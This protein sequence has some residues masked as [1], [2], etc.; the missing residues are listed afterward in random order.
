MSYCKLK[1][2]FKF[3]AFVILSECFSCLY[4]QGSRSTV[5]V[6]L[7]KSTYWTNLDTNI[8]Q[9]VFIWN[10]G[11]YWPGTAKNVHAKGVIFFVFCHIKYKYYL[12]SITFVLNKKLYV[13]FVSELAKLLDIKEIKSQPYHLKSQEKIERLHGTWKRKLEYDK[14]NMIN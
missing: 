8:K 5:Q 9:F 14:V 1:A 3:W 12:L 10:I 11:K 4:V 7:K 6:S 13:G 2:G